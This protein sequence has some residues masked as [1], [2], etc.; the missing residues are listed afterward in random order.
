MSRRE[1]ESQGLRDLR[2]FG[3]AIIEVFVNNTS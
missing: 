3:S 1:L 2:S